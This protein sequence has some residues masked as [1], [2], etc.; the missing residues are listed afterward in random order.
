MTDDL[1]RHIS[2]YRLLNKLSLVASILL[3][4]AFALFLVAVW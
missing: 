2:R 3:P 4:V 1:A